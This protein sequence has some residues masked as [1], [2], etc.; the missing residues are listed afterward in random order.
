MSDDLMSGEPWIE[1]EDAYLRAHYHKV[2]VCVIADALRRSPPA[3]KDRAWSLGIT[4][5]RVPARPK[6]PLSEIWAAQEDR[7]KKYI[8]CRSAGLTSTEI[9]ELFSV[10]RGAVIGTIYRYLKRVGAK[11]AGSTSRRNHGAL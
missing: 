3:V 8:G 7:A 4:K 11:S 9:G 6:R 10:S 2:D 1:A 5:K